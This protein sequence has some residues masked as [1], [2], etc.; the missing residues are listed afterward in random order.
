MLDHQF[1][2]APSFLA[3][4]VGLTSA[5]ISRRISRGNILVIAK[6]APASGVVVPISE[7][8]RFIAEMSKIPNASRPGRKPRP[9]A[10]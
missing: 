3:A 2:I 1:G 6:P 8:K 4:A 7:A 10:A 5:A 9:K